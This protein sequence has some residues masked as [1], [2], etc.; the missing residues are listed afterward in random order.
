M[1][2]PNAA[3]FSLSVPGRLCAAPTSTT[4]AFPHGGTI[5]GDVNELLFTPR[6]EVYGID[7]E[8]LGSEFTEYSL[9]CERALLQ[10]ELSGMT[11]AMLAKVLAH[12]TSGKGGGYGTSGDDSRR[13]SDSA[14]VLYFSPIYPASQFG[15][16]MYSAVGA[17]QQTSRLR[18]RAGSSGGLLVAFLG[19]RHAT[20]GVYDID[21]PADLSVP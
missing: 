20:K 16:L 15:L 5:L 4:G 7:D 17:F 11:A 13:G 6:P 18:L 14:F 10:V 19:L 2:D 9:S 8:S 12:V 21:L 1:A 3:T